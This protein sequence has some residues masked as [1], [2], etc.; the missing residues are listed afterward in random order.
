MNFILPTI[1]S[2]QMTLMSLKNLY[3]HENLEKSFTQYYLLIYILQ[4]SFSRLSS[5][6]KLKEKK[7]LQ[8]P[9]NKYEFPNNSFSFSSMSLSRFFVFLEQNNSRK[10]ETKKWEKSRFFFC[11]H[12][13]SLLFSTSKW[14]K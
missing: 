4:P 12:S 14:E 7:N 9:F 11:F 1:L 2:I 10:I 6:S 3:D 13:R 5:S 8:N